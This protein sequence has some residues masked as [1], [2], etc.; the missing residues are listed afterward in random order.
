MRRGALTAAIALLAVILSTPLAQ[1]QTYTVLH[2][3]AGTDGANPEAGLTLDA[4]GNLYG[5]TY[6]GG[7][8]GAGAV[9]QLNAAGEETVLYS[10][11]GGLDGGLPQIGSLL[12]DRS[13][14]LFG[15]TSY[16]G[17]GFGTVFRLSSTGHETVLHRFTLGPGGNTPYAGLVRDTGGNFYGSTYTGGSAGQGLVF[18]LTSSGSE[19]VLHNFTGGADGGGPFGD[20]LLD[21]KGNLFGTALFAFSGGVVFKLTTGGKETVLYTFCSQPNCADG[22]EPTGSLIQDAT[23]NLYG[24]ATAGGAF[25]NGAVFKVNP[26]GQETVLYSFTGGTDGSMPTAGLAMDSVGNLYGTTFF[27]GA[28]GTGVV[29]E[30]SPSGTYTVLYT[31]T[32]GTDGGFPYEAT[33]ISD[34]SGNLYGTA[35]S[36]GDLSACFGFGCGVVFKLTP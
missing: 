7:A 23:G 24:T 15:T 8:S 22:S 13:G 27:G 32:G 16:G 6:S 5:T 19:H 25:G 35:S 3:F 20:L 4:S 2:S 26:S 30:L 10:F 21:G 9:F 31:F 29:F 36:G 14:N 12:R 11:T 34:S 33:L 17:Y 1:A 18:R 28:Y